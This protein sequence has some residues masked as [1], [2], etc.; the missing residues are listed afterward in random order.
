MLKGDQ[1]T[2]RAINR[3]PIVNHLRRF[4]EASRNELV[5]ATGLSGAAVTFVTAELIDE[6]LV[7]EQA[8]A[9]GARDAGRLISITPRISPS[10][11][12]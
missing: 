8:T 9:R 3:R 2:S 10:G 12:S 11:S 1:Q 5:E 4:G 7:A 6:G